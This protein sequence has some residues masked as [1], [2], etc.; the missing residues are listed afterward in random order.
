MYPF[1][2][3]GGAQY[4]STLIVNLA[5]KCREDEYYMDLEQI[6]VMEAI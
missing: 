1:A 2:T 6:M 5:V 4:I 3:S